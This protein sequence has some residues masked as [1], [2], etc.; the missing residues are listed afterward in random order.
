M[1]SGTST[2]QRPQSS[3]NV[4]KVNGTASPASPPAPDSRPKTTGTE[5]PQGEKKQQKPQVPPPCHPK[6]RKA[7]VF[8]LEKYQHVDDYA[9]NVGSLWEDNASE[10]YDMG[11]KP[12]TN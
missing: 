12:I 1:G 11:V 6:R 7:D 3:P 2:Q 10:T 5:R 8:A 9:L 4:N